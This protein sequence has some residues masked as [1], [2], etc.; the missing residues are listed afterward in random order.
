VPV[1]RLTEE[2]RK[3]LSDYLF[4]ADKG[5]AKVPPVLR[6]TSGDVVAEIR[7]LQQRLAAYQLVTSR[8]PGQF[9][10]GPYE[11]QLRPL[12]ERFKERV[13]DNKSY[14][15]ALERLQVPGENTLEKG[16]GKP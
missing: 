12:I 9:R 16:K 14:Q 8:L 13:P 10:K 4:P 7:F 1:Y 15:A 6:P 11:V 2:Q 3:A 5:V